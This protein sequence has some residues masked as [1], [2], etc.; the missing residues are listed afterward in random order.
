M[1][2]QKYKIANAGYR[3]VSSVT[4]VIINLLSYPLQLIVVIVINGVVDQAVVGMS[5]D[6]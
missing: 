1:N 2:V 5:G 6:R 3:S 4:I